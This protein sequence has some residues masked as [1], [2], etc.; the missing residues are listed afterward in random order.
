MFCYI[1]FLQN[2][3]GLSCDWETVDEV[4]IK[5]HKL[6]NDLEFRKKERSKNG[7]LQSP[8]LRSTKITN[9][10]RISTPVDIASID[11]AG[12][13]KDG[14]SP[15]AAA[16]LTNWRKNF[17]GRTIEKKSKFFK[18]T[19]AEDNRLEKGY[20]RNSSDKYVLVLMK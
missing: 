2:S 4:A 13:A 6:Q 9:R 15:V 5:E 18:N 11:S 17:H 7:K 16:G 3:F 19:E 1:L 10:D 20:A 12:F 14:I 8:F